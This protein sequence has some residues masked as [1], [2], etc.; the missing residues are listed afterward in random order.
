MRHNR[1]RET[2]L[3]LHIGLLIHNR[4]R[5]RDLIDIFFEKSTSVSYD[6]VLQ[7]STEEA[8]RVTNMFEEGIVCPLILKNDQ[9]T[10]RNLGNI[11]H[12]PSSTSSCD[13]LHGTVISV[14]QH[15]A[16][17]N[18]GIHR[19]L[20]EVPEKEG[21]RSL[22]S[23]NALPKSNANVPP[24]VLPENVSPMTTNKQVIPISTNGETWNGHHCTD[25]RSC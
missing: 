19:M 6:Q 20:P 15:A 16:R 12:N 9:F 25:Y 2:A 4:T 10:T 18:T 14:T 3:T 21:Q 7:V 24:E 13:A 8:N 1:D 23:V 17:E 11:D 5:K 22:K